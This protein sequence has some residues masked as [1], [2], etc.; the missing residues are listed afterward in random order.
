MQRNTGE[1]LCAQIESVLSYEIADGT[2]SAGVQIPTEDHLI[3]RFRM[4][5][6]TVRRAVQNLV[7]RGLVEIRRGR[8]TFVT[9]PRITLGLIRIE[10]TSYTMGGRTNRLREAALSRRSRPLRHPAVTEFF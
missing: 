9:L 3:V 8:G 5:R 2:L 4:S 6:I 1:P 10:R 7:N